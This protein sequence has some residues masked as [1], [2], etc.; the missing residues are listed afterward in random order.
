M[1]IFLTHTFIN[2]HLAKYLLLGKHFIIIPLIL[3]LISLIIS[4]LIEQLKKIIHYQDC[5]NYLL[6]KIE[7]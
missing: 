5:V 6:N 1:N 3:L 2:I 4:I 7:N